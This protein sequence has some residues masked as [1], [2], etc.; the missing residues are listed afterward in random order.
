[1]ILILC[2]VYVIQFPKRVLEAVP[3][4]PTRQVRLPKL[5]TA[6]RPPP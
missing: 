5:A 1:M 2:G 6:G 4:Q 3:G